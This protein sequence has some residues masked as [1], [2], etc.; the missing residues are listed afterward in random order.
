ML[1]DAAK[2]QFR[3][4]Q[5]LS[6]G[7][8]AGVAFFA[9]VAAFL[10]QQGTSPSGSFDSIPF[11]VIAAVGLVAIFLAPRI[12]GMI[13]GRPTSDEDAA[14]SNLTTSVIV[15]QAIREGVGFMGIALA[16]LAGDLNWIVVFTVLSVGAMVLGLPKERDVEEALRRVKSVD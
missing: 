6:F 5:V 10:V 13:R 2:K 7:L 4:M 1:S 11:P 8:I 3:V 12:G 16:L 15:A 14:L 9:V